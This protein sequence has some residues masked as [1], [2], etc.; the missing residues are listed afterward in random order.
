MSIRESYLRIDGLMN[1]CHW[2]PLDAI[3]CH[4]MPLDAKYGCLRMATIRLPLQSSF[5]ALAI[6]LIICTVQ[7]VPFLIAFSTVRVLSCIQLLPIVASNSCFPMLT[8]DNDRT[9]ANS[10]LEV[11]LIFEDAHK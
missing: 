11:S 8:S 5:S 2:M 9:E 7:S 10:N 4:W 6:S 3:G 1:G